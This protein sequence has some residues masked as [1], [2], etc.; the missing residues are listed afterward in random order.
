MIPVNKKLAITLYFLRNTGS[1][2]MAANVFDAALST[3]LKHSEVC[4]AVTEHFGSKYILLPRTEEE[5]IQK[6]A[7]FE[8]KSR[9]AQLFGCIDGSHVPILRPIENSQ[10]SYCYE[11]FFTLT[12]QTVYDFRSFYGC[13]PQVAWLRP[14]C[15][16]SLQF[17]Y[18]R[19]LIEQKTTDET[20]R[21]I[22]GR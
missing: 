11:K 5:M 22:P 10:D 14:R 19:D 6:S 3:A 17:K 2:L 15:Q 21:N 16:N 4:K 7:E 12:V 9:M 1:L 13:G 18:K 8:R 20:S